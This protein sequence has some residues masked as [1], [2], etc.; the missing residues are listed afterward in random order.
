MTES[1]TRERTR[2]AVLAAAIDI[3]REDPAASMAQVAAGA[4]VARST[5]HR[6]YPDRPA[7]IAGIEDFV[8]GVYESALDAARVDEGSAADALRRAVG[9]LVEQM[10]ILAWWLDI[11]DDGNDARLEAVVARGHR[12]GS[13]DPAMDVAW[14]EAMLWSGLWSAHYLI[15]SGTYRMP[16]AR[17]LCIRTFAKVITP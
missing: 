3:L 11:D 8:A 15:R 14:I 4:G 10:Q 16:E 1:A 12:D 2:R 7:L 5:L 13:V 9:E 17:D 6:Y